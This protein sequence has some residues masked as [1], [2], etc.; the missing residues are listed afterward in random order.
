M[1]SGELGGSG[2]V[3]SCVYGWVPLMIYHFDCIA[4][5]VLPVDVIFATAIICVSDQRGLF[6]LVGSFVQSNLQI[7]RVPVI[8]LIRSPVKYGRPCRLTGGVRLCCY[9]YN[10]KRLFTCA[11]LRPRSCKRI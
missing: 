9:R 1:C 4:W 5:W 10:P 2:V 6:V 11:A 7:I 8:A 3:L